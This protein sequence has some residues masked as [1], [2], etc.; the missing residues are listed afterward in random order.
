MEFFSAWPEWMT[1]SP[2]WPI[3]AQPAS[4]RSPLEPALRDYILLITILVAFLEA[5]NWARHRPGGQSFGCGDRRQ[6]H[7]EA[8]RWI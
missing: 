2:G 5:T 4:P 8:A 6:Q 1:S 3:A 7:P